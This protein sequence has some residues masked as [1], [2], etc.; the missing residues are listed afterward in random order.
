VF[1]YPY[2]DYNDEIKRLVN[3][4]GFTAAFTMN[5]G[6]NTDETD[7]FELR[8]TKISGIDTLFDFRKKLA[9]AYDILHR[10]VRR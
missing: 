1:C 9:G 2:G 6:K 3:K 10:V 8:R 4:A 7:R 5:P